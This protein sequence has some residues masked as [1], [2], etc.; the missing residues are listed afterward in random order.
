MYC[1]ELE[2]NLK[3]SVSQTDTNLSDSTPTNQNMDY[4]E[5]TVYSKFKKFQFFLHI[6]TQ[7]IL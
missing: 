7:K 6:N 4:P 5:L 3:L 1:S 2:M